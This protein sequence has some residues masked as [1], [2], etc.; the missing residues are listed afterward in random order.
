VVV[1]N[2]SGD[3]AHEFEGWFASPEAFQ[4]QHTGGHVFCPVCGDEYR[5]G[6]TRCTD[7]DSDLVER[8]PPGIETADP[9][10]LVTIL[11]TGDQSQVAWTLHGLG[12]LAYRQGDFAA[13][14]SLLSEALADLGWS[15]Y[16]QKK[17]AESAA[18]FARLLQEHPD[19]AL[20]PEAAFMRGKSLEDAG[21]IPEAQVAFAEARS[22]L[23]R[24][25]VLVGTRHA[26]V[27]DGAGG[28]LVQPDRRQDDQA[29]DELAAAR[30]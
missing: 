26:D 18:S 19:D 24:V 7:C 10:E 20:V 22:R 14:R 25:A 27:V 15:Q 1:Y 21:K 29:G 28:G 9:F 6:I 16:R 4:H 5:A 8:L 11:E 23:P 30:R 2:L 3:N 12:F 13:A 17:F